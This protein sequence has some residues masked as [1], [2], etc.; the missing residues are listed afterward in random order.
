M[1]GGQAGLLLG[2]DSSGV[3]VVMGGGALLEGASEGVEGQQV[4]VHCST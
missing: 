4:R 3:V 1:A 2:T